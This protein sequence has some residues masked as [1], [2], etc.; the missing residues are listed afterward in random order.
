[1]S[2]TPTPK[3]YSYGEGLEVHAIERRGEAI[4]QWERT[5]VLDGV[6]IAVIVAG[7]CTLR[8]LYFELR[9]LDG[10]PIVGL[11]GEWASVKKAA[12]AAAELMRAA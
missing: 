11:A 4:S 2:S 5:V 3:R 9:N 10:S 6:A 8:T 12:K 7:R 1:M